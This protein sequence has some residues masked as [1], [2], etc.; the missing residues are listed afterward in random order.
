M[1]SYFS[2]LW[3]PEVLFDAAKA[4]Q[5]KMKGNFRNGKY[6]HGIRVRWMRDESISAQKI[7]EEMIMI[8]MCS[9]SQSDAIVRVKAA[10]SRLTVCFYTF[11]V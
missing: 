6:F 2:W 11:Y 7:H 3:P 5:T 4:N 10:C 8:K 1:P 9:R